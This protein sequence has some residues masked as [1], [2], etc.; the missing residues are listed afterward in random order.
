MTPFIPREII[1]QLSLGF[2][3]FPLYGNVLNQCSCK[4][5]DCSSPAKHPIIFNSFRSATNNLQTISYWLKRFPFCN[6]AVATGRPSNIVVLDIDLRKDGHQSIKDITIP[7]T[8]TVLTGNGYH[9][10]FKLP[11][12]YHNLRSFN[13]ILQGVDFKANNAY[14]VCPP[15]THINGRQYEIHTESDFAEIPSKILDLILEKKN[16]ENKIYEGKRNSELFRIGLGIAHNKIKDKSRL[17][18]YLQITNLDRC[19]P[20]L[21]PSEVKLIRNNILKIINGKELKG[22][23]NI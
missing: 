7:L 17:L 4:K 21:K 9:Y 22:S 5:S 23:L 2:K 1:T 10:Y 11:R 8:Y 14:V 6:F 12:K 18:K 15:S 16:A 13:G 20:P 3:I 19:S